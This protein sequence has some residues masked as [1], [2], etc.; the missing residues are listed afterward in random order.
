MSDYIRTERRDRPEPAPPGPSGSTPFKKLTAPVGIRHGTQVTNRASDQRAVMYMLDNVQADIGGNRNGDGSLVVFWPLVDEGRCHEVLRDGI[1]RFQTF[2]FTHGGTGKP[3]G[4]LGFKPDGVVDPGGRTAQLL[5]S[6]RRAASLPMPASD[7][8]EVAKA[9]IPLA[10]TWAQGALTYLQ[11]YRAWRIRKRGAPLFDATA[12]NVHLHL[13]RLGDI[14]SIRRIDEWI[15][16]YQKILGALR[17][18]EHVFVRATRE[19]ALAARNEMNCFGVSVPAWA[20]ANINI[21]FGPDMLGLGP[22]CKSAILIHEAGHFVAAKIGHQGGER[23]FAYD[24]Q[25]ADQA[26]TSAYVCANFATHATTGKDE[27]FGLARPR[28]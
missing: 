23:G 3:P 1:L 26:L 8:K 17:N 27:R 7:V 20:R 18:A 4:A 2:F 11:G 10:T 28:E 24:N 13:D 25:S 19:E 9:A 6:N 14:D 16:N 21:W 12:A 22:K 15:S 5:H